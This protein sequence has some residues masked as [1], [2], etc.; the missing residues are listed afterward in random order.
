VVDGE[1]EFDRYAEE[2]DAMHSASIAGFGEPTGYF[3]EYK[4]REIARATG[5][6]GTAGAGSG[7]PAICDFGAGVGGS[8]P[9]VRKYFPRAEL[10]CVDVSRQSLEVAESR[11]PG[12]ARYLP[13]EGGALPLPPDS[14]D[15]VY[16]NC[17]FHHIEAAEHPKVLRELLRVLR[18]GGEVFVFEHNPWN[19]ITVRVVERCP[20]D[21][22]ARLV[23]APLMRRRL[24]EA[25]FRSPAIRYRVFFPRL[26]RALRPL[27]VALGWLPLGG[28]YFVS[29]RK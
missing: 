9:F 18:P 13:Y 22:N 10:T 23:A 12:W 27:E 25:G 20:F 24:I 4:I 21:E 28:Q 11:F 26:L 19:P 5:Q 2:Y 16:A 3:A 17:V 29:A 14:F 1:R 6:A 8:V 7:R 15:I